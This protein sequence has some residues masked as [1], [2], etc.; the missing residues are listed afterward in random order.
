[1]DKEAKDKKVGIPTESRK[2]ARV[3][4]RIK[5][6]AP[7]VKNSFAAIK[8]NVEGFIDVFKAGEGRGFDDL[9]KDEGY[10]A[11][12]TDMLDKAQAAIDNIDA[13]TTTLS[14]QALAI[15]DSTTQ[16]ACAMHMLVTTR[17]TKTIAGAH[18]RVFSKM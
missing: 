12:A 4:C 16:E 3:S 2:S 7:Y 5:S 9:F 17:H 6:S 14:A 11:T 15:D 18:L 1:M 10:E 13:A 8:A